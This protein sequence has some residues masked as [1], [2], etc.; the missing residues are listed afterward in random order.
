MHTVMSGSL[1]FV[2][3]KGC[4]LTVNNFTAAA[5]SG[6]LDVLCWAMEVKCPL[7]ASE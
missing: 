1:K 5:W 6:R 7:I 2:Y 3:S 4:E